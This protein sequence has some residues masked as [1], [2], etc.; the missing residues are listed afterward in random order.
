MTIHP[1]QCRGQERVGAISPPPLVACMVVAGQL[2][3]FTLQNAE[4]FIN[5]N[6]NNETTIT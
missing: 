2:Y 5:D 4:T 3:F 1:I 6:N